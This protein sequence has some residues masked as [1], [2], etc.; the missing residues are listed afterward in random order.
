MT[1]NPQSEPVRMTEAQ[2]LALEPVEGVRYEYINGKIYAMSGASHNHTKI[3]TDFLIAFGTRIDRDSCEVFNS[4]LRVSY[5]PRHNYYYPDVTIVCGEPD[6]VPEQSL[7]TITNPSIIVEVLSPSTEKMDRT[8]KWLDYRQLPSLQEY[9][10]VAQ[11]KPVVEQFIRQTGTPKI[12]WLLEVTTGLDKTITLPSLGITIPMAEIYSRAVFDE[13][14]E[15]E[16]A[17]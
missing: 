11:D 17:T 4:D 14:G 7:I 16:T 5:N 13:I 9:I 2:Y 1:A 6:Y 10:L 12:R 15:E 8:V 3:S